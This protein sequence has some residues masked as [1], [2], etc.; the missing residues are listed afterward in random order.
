MDTVEVGKRGMI[1]A[2]FTCEKHH[3]ITLFAVDYYRSFYKGEIKIICPESQAWH[4]E[5][6]GLDVVTDEELNNYSELREIAERFKMHSGW[7]LQQFLK[8]D[9]YLNSNDDVLIIDGD[10]VLSEALFLASLRNDTLFYNSENVQQYSKCCVVFLSLITA[11]RRA[12]FAISVLSSSLVK[13]F[14]RKI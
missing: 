7:Y 10:T 14:T 13:I 6:L 3:K 11:V 2:I 1:V 5:G 4:F 12:I 8:L 9:Y